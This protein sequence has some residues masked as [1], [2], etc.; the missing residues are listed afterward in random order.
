[1]ALVMDDFL[2]LSRHRQMSSMGLLPITVE[3][4]HILFS[5]NTKLPFTFNVYFRYI[6]ALDSIL[7]THNQSS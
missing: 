5:A 1:M 4:I 6:S 7:L 3:A 2:M